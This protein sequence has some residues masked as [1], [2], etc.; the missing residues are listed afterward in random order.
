MIQLK[1][2]KIDQYGQ[3]IFDEDELCKILLDG[4][5]IKDLVVETTD[6]IRQFN[7]L[8][9]AWDNGEQCLIYYQ[10]YSETPAVFHQKRQ[11]IWLMSDGFKTVDVG[12]WLLQK[13][14][15]NAEIERVI[16]ELELFSERNML[17]VLQFL[18]FLV[19]HFRSRGIVWG[20]GRGSSVASFCLYLIGIHR[21]N[22]L[23][24]DLDIKEFLK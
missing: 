20:V 3:V 24:Y 23:R 14:S 15:N 2:R 8:Y 13:C 5:S 17:S 18:I 1:G 7:S 21:I 6:R 11:D 4:G 16:L 19:D 12:E 10:P 9:K 22:S